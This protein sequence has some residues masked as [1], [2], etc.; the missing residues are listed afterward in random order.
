MPMKKKPCPTCD[1]LMGPRSSQ[2][3]KCKPTYERTA[4][5]N[6]ALSARLKGVPKP[7]LKGRKRPA[8]AARMKAVWSDPAMR[9]AAQERG[10]A[11][12]AD[13][14]WVKKIAE[15]VS[16]EKNPRWKGGISN[17][18]YA[19]GFSRRLKE[20]IRKRDGRRCTLCGVTEAEAGYR[21]SIHHSD[22]DKSNHDPDNLFS[23]CK[24]C[25][26]RVNTNR[27]VWPGYF[28]ALLHMSR[29]LGKDISDLIDRKVITQ[30]EGLISI[31][32]G[33]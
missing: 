16:G 26:S 22:Y 6:A 30:N 5:H 20:R 32:H 33:G 11:F 17:G 2:C 4:E 1:G 10:R 18:E 25:N 23:T 31:V 29:Q 7:H 14:A 9:A 12:A 3:R 19:P 21:M 8:H 24:A 15:S 28:A 13:P 27:D